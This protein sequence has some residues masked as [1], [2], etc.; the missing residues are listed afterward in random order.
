MVFCLKMDTGYARH[1]DIFNAPFGVRLP[2][3]ILGKPFIGEFEYKVR[4]SSASSTAQSSPAGRV[5][6]SCLLTPGPNDPQ[7]RQQGDGKIDFQ[8]Y[9]QCGHEKCEDKKEPRTNMY[10]LDGAFYCETHKR[11]GARA[12]N[13]AQEFSPAT[14]SFEAFARRPGKQGIVDLV[15]KFTA[16]Y[17]MPYLNKL[18]RLSPI[19]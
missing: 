14:L 1:E 9:P 2:N 8:L 12:V 3:S 11:K 13:L 7:T 6:T 4:P 19:D 17:L 18:V 15:N 16:G 5:F 10:T